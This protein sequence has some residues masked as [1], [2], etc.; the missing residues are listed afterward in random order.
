MPKRKEG[1]ESQMQ[2]SKQPK[3]LQTHKQQQRPLQSRTDTA[4]LERVPGH[5]YVIW[6]NKGGA[7]KT[8]LVFHLSTQ[9]AI[10]H[11]NK[12]VLVIDMCPQA[13]VSTALLS[14]IHASGKDFAGKTGDLVLSEDIIKGPK[15]RNDYDKSVCGYMMS[16]LS[17]QDIPSEEFLT[18][19]YNYNSYIPNNMYLLCGDPYLEVIAKRLEQERQLMKI[20]NNNPWKKVTLYLKT[21]IEK[22]GKNYTVFIDTNPSFSVYTELA[23][24]AA[25]RMIVPVNADDFSRNATNSLLWLVYGIRATENEERIAMYGESEREEFSYKAVQ[26]GIQVPKIYLVINN[27]VTPY[28]FRS[29]KAFS[30]KAC[31]IWDLLKTVSRR[32]DAERIFVSLEENNYKEEIGD[33]H[34]NAIQ[35]LHLGCPLSELPSKVTMKGEKGNMNIG[36]NAKNCKENFLPK[37]QAIV[38]RL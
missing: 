10:E 34:S 8:T 33:F 14:G 15:V 6:N 36:T 27:R 28:K 16:Q 9:Y 17:N 5:H 25:T 24:S 30:A 7:G 20:N 37:L 11:E 31:E 3:L 22:L 1:Q 32:R 23:I 29:S 13:N 2:K 12:K 19:P 21:F 38:K 26:S 4:D 35:C 18:R